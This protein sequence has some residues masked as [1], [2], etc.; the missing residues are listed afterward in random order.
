[1]EQKLMNNSKNYMDGI[2]VGKNLKETLLQRLSPLVKNVL[3]NH[4]LENG[5]NQNEM[6]KIRYKILCNTIE[7]LSK[8]NPVVPREWLSYC[9]LVYN[10]MKGSL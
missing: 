5:N 7:E 3:V 6:I 10:E 9:D 1:M 8:E 2:P 4:F